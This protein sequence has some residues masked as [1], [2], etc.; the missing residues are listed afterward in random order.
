MPMCQNALR[1]LLPSIIQYSLKASQ[2]M[3]K[4]FIVTLTQVGRSKQY[5]C[6]ACQ[7]LV[8]R[9][10]QI[11]KV[12]PMV[13]PTPAAADSTSARG[14]LTQ[15]GFCI[16]ALAPLPLL[17]NQDNSSPYQLQSRCRIFARLAPCLARLMTVR[18]KDESPRPT[19]H[20]HL[21][22][23]SSGIGPSAS[24]RC[25]PKRRPAGPR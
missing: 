12:V 13:E 15:R 10:I 8:S 1:K 22:Q 5:Q 20:R 23:R 4:A 19:W 9:E 2:A 11:R 18:M 14:H 16:L 17:G 21:S 25:A 3:S 6:P 24:S 7:E